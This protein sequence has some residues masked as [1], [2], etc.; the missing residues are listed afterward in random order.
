MLCGGA[1]G[2]RQKRQE[3]GKV[4]GRKEVGKVLRWKRKLQVAIIEL[5]KKN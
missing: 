1:E 3:L 4:L 5:C 2:Q